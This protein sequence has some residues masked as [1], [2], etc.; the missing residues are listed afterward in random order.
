M[1][2]ANAAQTPGPNLFLRHLPPNMLENELEMLLAPHGRLKRLTVWKDHETRQS[3]GFGMAEF[4]HTDSAMS[5]MKDLQGR[6]LGMGGLPLEIEYHHGKRR[7]DGTPDIG[8]PCTN[9]YVRG[10]P[11][12]M[13]EDQLREVLSQFGEILRLTIWKDQ[14]GRSKGFGMCEFKSSDQARLAL[15]SLKGKSLDHAQQLHVEVNPP[16]PPVNI[17]TN[18]YQAQQGPI[19]NLFVK[20]FPLAFEDRDLQNLV[21]GFGQV[22]RAT[23]WRDRTTGSSK[24]FGLVEFADTQQAQSALN[25]LNGAI[26]EG[27]NTALQVEYNH[28]RNKD[29]LTNAN[30]NQCSNIFLKCLP[31]SYSDA[32]LYALLSQYGRIVRS[33]IWKDTQTNQ[34]RGF[35]FCEFTTPSSANAAIV[36]LNGA[37]LQG[38][39]TPIH[40]E[41]HTKPPRQKHNHTVPPGQT[42][43][44][45]F[46]KGLPKH[47]GE[48]ELKGMLEPHGMLVRCTVWKD[49]TTQESKGFGMA[50]FDSVAS[51]TTAIN[52]LN[53]VQL[54]GCTSPLMMEFHRT[55]TGNSIG[56]PV[57]SGASTSALSNPMA[58]HAFQPALMH[59]MPTHFPRSTPT[60]P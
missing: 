9:L 14:F 53:N 40:V 52:S 49:R 23:I 28:P 17:N 54:P 8:A 24:G 5:A 41:P 42:S 4:E 43:T 16:K 47:Y 45:V 19:P 46:I 35:G 22:K 51:A 15:D 56:S 6:E 60:F 21:K 12:N 33:T 55:G 36:G 30:P 48:A 37:M 57:A 7:R 58:M 38:G 31:L 20:G 10:L 39:L 25:A 34:S 18:Q 32:D 29:S 27:S 11:L 13:T 2:T 3:K 59:Q 50:Q 44:N 26:L 1:R